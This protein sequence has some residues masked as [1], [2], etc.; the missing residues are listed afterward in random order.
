[1]K[2]HKVRK[3]TR[4]TSYGDNADTIYIIVSGRIVITWPKE[5]L[6]AMID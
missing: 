4:L 3:G 5:E 2:L 1:M 6:K